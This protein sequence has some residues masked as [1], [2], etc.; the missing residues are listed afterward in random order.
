[1]AIR[2]LAEAVVEKLAHLLFVAGDR[3]DVHECSSELE[4]IHLFFS[5]DEGREKKKP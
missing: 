2:E 1:M 5:T 4:K 3:F